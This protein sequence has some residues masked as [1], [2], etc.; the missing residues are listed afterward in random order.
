MLVDGRP[1][2]ERLWTRRKAKSL[3]KILALAPNHQL[4]REQ[5]MEMLWPEA[6][7]EL[8]ANNLHKALHAA[9]RVFEPELKTG[10]DSAF[11]PTQ[12]QTICLQ[13]PGG[14]W[15]DAE[16]FRRLAERALSRQEIDAHRAAL[17]LY[18]GELLEEDRYEDWAAASREQLQL[19][20][21][22]LIVSLAKRHESAGNLTE[23]IENYR[24]LLQFDKLN[25]DAHRNLM[26]IYF[27]TGQRSLALQQFQA[28]RLNLQNEL[29]AAPEAA[30]LD[31][32]ERILSGD[33]PIGP[34]LNQDAPV[35]HQAAMAEKTEPARP[36][37]PK[38]RVYLAIS[39]I[40]IV[41]F[42]LLLFQKEKKPAQDSIAVLPFTNAT[43]DAEVD[44]LSD[45]LSESLI[46]NLSQ[47]PNL[48]VIART[49]AFRY[50][51]PITDPVVAGRQ[52]MVDNVITGKL[53]RQGDEFIVQAD[54]VRVND[55]AQIW[56]QQYRRRFSDLVTL[57]SEI[58][59][60]LS[61]RLRAQLSTEQQG[62]V[63]HQHTTNA[64]AYQSYLKGRYYWNL[65]KVT[66]V[67]RAIEHFK[68]AIAQ[69][70]G[71]A[72]AYAGLA[73]C[74]HTLSNLKLPPTEA[75]PLARHAANKALEIDEKVAGAHA[76]LAI[77][78]WRFDWDW[79]GA[80]REFLRA[81]ELD[82]NYASAHQWYGQFLTYQKKF[83][84]GLAEL[85]K[86][87]QNDPLS[88]I[89]TA[90]I[91][92]PL[93]FSGDYDGAISQFHRA[94]EF[95]KDFPF[96]H[97]FIGWAL[98]QK[99]E[100]AE[101]IAQ[102]QQ[103]VNIDATP[104]ALAYLGYG[105]AVAG[106]S[107]EAEKILLRLQDLSR[108]RYVSPYYLAVVC[109]GLEKDHLALGY[110][111]KAFEDHSDPMVLIGVEP[112]FDRL[113]SAPAFQELLRRIGLAR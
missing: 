85:K 47:I 30:T 93:F 15:I 65:R 20:A 100:Y 24:R 60:E 3:V 8:A 58:S 107:A 41:I 108:T 35:V 39:A 97:F 113:R 63:A 82:P 96:G 52:M 89:I 21:Q 101:A 86:A 94:F 9:R 36:G 38:G 11:L 16:E 71:Y 27:L 69:D 73:D 29:Q 102:F 105:Q 14:L 5:L 31:L 112:K 45:G 2:D 79:P 84:Q 67:E 44:Y 57:Q 23:A 50:K 40:I 72:L 42:L 95:Q 51:S 48:R 55:G 19:L 106:N 110:L 111:N 92:L 54:L 18:A 99:R 81:I 34:A 22:R 25:E 88:P 83:D 6:E 53:I 70:P 103:A 104:S 4:H 62:R 13:A 91:G 64:I 90:N 43:G 46:N 32:Y 10:P 78:K 77:G 33:M 7:P 75:I 59:R 12:D 109:A 74:Y 76:S 28:C 17:E 61:Q 66:D 80:E 56:G 68:E 1:I 26:R 49:T 98:V 87:Q 37:I